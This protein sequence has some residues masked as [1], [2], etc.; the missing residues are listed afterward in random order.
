MPHMSEY[1]VSSLLII[2]ALISAPFLTS[3]EN[4]FRVLVMYR[5]AQLQRSIATFAIASINISTVFDEYRDNYQGFDCT[6][7]PSAKEYDHLCYC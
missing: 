1:A 7:P 2:L 3:T 5:A 6:L 4:N